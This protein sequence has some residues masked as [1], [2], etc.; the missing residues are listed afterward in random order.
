MGLETRGAGLVRGLRSEGF[1]L[2]V[3]ASVQAAARRTDAGRFGSRFRM[4]P[5][6]MYRMAAERDIPS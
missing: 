4:N 1:P 3:P 5:Q 6:T 2:V